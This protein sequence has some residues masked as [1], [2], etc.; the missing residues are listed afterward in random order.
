MVNSIL[1]TS[2]CRTNPSQ[3]GILS[4]GRE[5]LERLQIREFQRADHMGVPRQRDK[6][7]EHGESTK[8]GSNKNESHDCVEDHRST[9]VKDVRHV[10]DA[11]KAPS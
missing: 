9:S 1:C 3:A 6:H 7:R 10:H 11:Q 4:D 8:E 2:F 5:L